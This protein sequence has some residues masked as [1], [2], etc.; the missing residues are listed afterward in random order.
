MNMAGVLSELSEQALLSTQGGSPISKNLSKD[1]DTVAPE[2]TRHDEETDVLKQ[3]VADLP[4]I[5]S[6]VQPSR[7]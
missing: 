6:Q 3:P 5:E 7:P 4:L 2:A 1:I